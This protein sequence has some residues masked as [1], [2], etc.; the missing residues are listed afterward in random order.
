VKSHVSV[1][2]IKIIGKP[3]FINDIKQHQ[4][5]WLKGLTQVLVFGLEIKA[6]LCSS[7]WNGR[8]FWS[9]IRS[10]LFE[11]QSYVVRLYIEVSW[12]HR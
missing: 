9:S 6:S 11:D 1:I 5:K 4:T 3:T 12:K 10:K 8:G 2:K 7:S